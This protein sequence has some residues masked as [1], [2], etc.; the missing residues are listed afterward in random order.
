MM[1]K[2]I[3]LILVPAYFLFLAYADVHADQN[4]QESALD[5]GR[6]IVTASKFEQ[7]Y[8]NSTQNISIIDK[9]EIESSGAEDVAEILDL[10]PSVNIIDYGSYGST[11]TVH[12]RG[13]SNSQVITLLNGRVINTPRDGVADLNQI[14][15][16]NIERIEVLRGPASSIYGANAVGGVI[17][18]ITRQGKEKMFTELNIKS[19]SFLTNSM[20]F[21]N[22]WKIG[23][24]DYFV[25]TNII[26][27]EGHRDNSDYRKQNY[28]LRLGYEINSGNKLTF[29]SGYVTSEVGTPGRNSDVDMDDRQEQFKNYFDL[30]WKGSCWEDSKVLLKLYQNLDRLEFTESLSP[31]L[32]KD[33]NQTKVYGTDF[34]LSQTWFKVFR[35]SLGLSGQKNLLNSSTSAKH[36]YNLRAA[37]AETELDL[38]KDL[39]VKGGLRIDDYSNFENKTS[40]SASFSWWFFDKIKTHGLL[41]KSFRAPTFNDL[42]WPREDWG[43]WGG[44]EGNPSLKPETATSR[45]I[46]AGTLLFD[47]IEADITYFHNK[48]K[49]M[50]TWAMDDAYW[51]RP[52]NVNTAVI[53]GVETSL[54]CQVNKDLKLNLNYTRLSATDTA[55]N[56]WI[57]YRPRHQYKGSIS[58]NFNDKLNCYLAGKYLSKRYTTDTNS[59]FLKSY[60]AADANVSYKVT[61]FGEITLTVNNILDRDY[62]EEEDYPMPGT[63]F[64]L[65]TK[66]TF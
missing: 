54:T 60:F 35:T 14:P 4:R 56:K 63:S 28:D 13:A 49:D 53:K 19:G 3:N 36:D 20:D 43:V 48:F 31:V 24:W 59:R 30:T 46:G 62:Q 7:A 11:K 16:N 47:K 45:E 22:G 42:Y 17:N 10:L 64:M 41:A 40:P 65:G 15:L 52:S 5:M 9:Y 57:I 55:T 50:I 18:I 29:E 12:T 21:A 61:K 34:Q 27:S 33:T 44:V 8:R 38:F 32:D 2:N 25:T 66:F 39:S 58:Y 1:K 26:E 51:W 23:K 37:Y 6:I